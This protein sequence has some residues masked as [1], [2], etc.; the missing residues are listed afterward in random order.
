MLKEKKKK[1][2]TPYLLVFNCT[3]MQ[4]AGSRIFPILLGLGAVPKTAQGLLTSMTFSENSVAS[5][6]D[7][8]LE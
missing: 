2:K 6:G 3:P 4:N 1:E 7:A 8:G 5:S